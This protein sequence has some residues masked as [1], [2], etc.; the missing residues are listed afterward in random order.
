MGA[1][2]EGVK[3]SLA[4]ELP[5][6]LEEID[7]KLSAQDKNLSKEVKVLSYRLSKWGWAVIVLLWVGVLVVLFEMSAL[8]F[9]FWRIESSYRKNLEMTNP[10]KAVGILTEIKKDI[11]NLNYNHKTTDSMLRNLAE[12]IR[13]LK[14]YNEVKKPIADIVSDQKI[15]TNLVRNLEE[16]LRELKAFYQNEKIII[17]LQNLEDELR[18]STAL[19]QL[20]TDPNIIDN[21]DVTNNLTQNIEEELK[22]ILQILEQRKKILNIN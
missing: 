9:D 17:E 18:K 21:P 13:E 12:Q 1:F 2:V 10:Q 19:S 4:D 11:T 7:R 5:P 8:L 16:E 6:I 22:H 14:I 20:N 3:M 15:L